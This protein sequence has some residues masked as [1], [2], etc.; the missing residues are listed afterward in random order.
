M[1]IT[2]KDLS[3]LN[4]DALNA[5]CGGAMKLMANLSAAPTLGGSGG[6][7]TISV[8]NTLAAAAAIPDAKWTPHKFA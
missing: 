1:S 6:N 4:I 3:E 8:G 7:V 2:K 5:V